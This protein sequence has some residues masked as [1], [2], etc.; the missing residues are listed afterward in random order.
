MI[1]PAENADPVEVRNVDESTSLCAKI[2]QMAVRPKKTKNKD[3]KKKQHSRTDTQSDDDICR[4]T[5]DLFG[6]TTEEDNDN[7]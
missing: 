2:K 7:D 4:D 6:T 5:D 1:Y 3:K